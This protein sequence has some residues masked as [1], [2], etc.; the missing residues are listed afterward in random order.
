MRLLIV[1]TTVA[2]SV[3]ATRLARL[4]VTQRLAACVH[5]ERIESVYCWNGALEQEPEL[6]LQFKTRADLFEPLRDWLLAEHPYEL[7]AIVALP[8]LDVLPAYADWVDA[9]T[10]REA[11]S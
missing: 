4:A 1:Q 2:E 8:V 7:P 5:I 11:A 10:H 6:R 9:E 3:D